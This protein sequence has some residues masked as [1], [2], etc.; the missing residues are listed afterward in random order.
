MKPNCS[1]VEQYNM[2]IFYKPVW[3]YF[4]PKLKRKDKTK[5]SKEG[6]ENL[7]K[8]EFKN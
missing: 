3:I 8:I 5:F 6:E 7:E 2:T 1:G 4:D